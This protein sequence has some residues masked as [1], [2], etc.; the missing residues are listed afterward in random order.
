M[1][2]GISLSSEPILFSQLLNTFGKSKRRAM[3]S[4]YFAVD[5][6]PTFAMYFHENIQ[7]LIDSEN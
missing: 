6:F 2:I 5:K 4:L 1:Y 7:L 3:L